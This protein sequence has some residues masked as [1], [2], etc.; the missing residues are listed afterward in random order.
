MWLQNKC[1]CV[2]HV[3]FNSLHAVPINLTGTAE[4]GDRAGYREGGPN[5][6]PSI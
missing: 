4:P 5:D 2:L 3:Y 1:A 6:D